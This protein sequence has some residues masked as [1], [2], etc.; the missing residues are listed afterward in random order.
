MFDIDKWIEERKA[1]W[2]EIVAMG[3]PD[4]IR[5]PQAV[6]DMS[7]EAYAEWLKEGNNN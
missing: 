3:D 5:D 1:R 4:E 6:M 2:A 7:D